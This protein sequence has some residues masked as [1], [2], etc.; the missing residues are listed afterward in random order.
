MLKEM[1]VV[2]KAVVGGL[3]VVIIV[4]TVFVAYRRRVPPAPPSVPYSTEGPA[5]PTEQM[6]VDVS[7]AVVRPGLYSLPVGSRIY[8]AIETAGG[9]TPEADRQSVN[10]A[11]RLK[12]GDQVLVKSR[13]AEKL[14][15]PSPPTVSPAEPA[16]A[17]QTP[18]TSTAASPTAA[19]FPLSLNQATLTQLMELPGVGE[20]TAAKIIQYRQAFGGFKRIEELKLIE[21]IGPKKF[22]Q[23]RPYVVP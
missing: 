1:T 5:T 15:P 10:L 9:F 23:I 20:K 4:A 17:P 2:Q 7:G 6:V 14:P 11:K 12:D 21:G 8:Q 19:T 22:E 13:A 16:V 3:V 18:A